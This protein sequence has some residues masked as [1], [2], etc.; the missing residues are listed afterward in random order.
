MKKKLDELTYINGS[1]IRDFVFKFNLTIII[2]Y[3]MI[4]IGEASITGT[5]SVGDMHVLLGIM[6]FAMIGVI[7]PIQIYTINYFQKTKYYM[8]DLKTVYHYH[9]KEFYN[10]KNI[11]VFLVTTL[12]YDLLMMMFIDTEALFFFLKIA[13][14][15]AISPLFVALG[16][17][18]IT[19][20]CK[21]YKVMRIGLYV[22]SYI[23]LIP[24]IVISI[25]F[26][27]YIILPVLVTIGV[28]SVYLIGLIVDRQGKSLEV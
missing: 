23:F 19:V 1:N 17:L 8:I 2:L 15:F 18:I 25:L 7:Y 3:A 6:P 9:L 24:L 27:T 14:G 11:L 21:G 16:F 22:L 13:S 26:N 28:L 12:V 20:Y 4:G 5:A 10:F